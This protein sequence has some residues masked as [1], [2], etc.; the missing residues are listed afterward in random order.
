MLYLKVKEKNKSYVLLAIIQA[1]I[2]TGVNVWLLCYVKMGI[3]GY[4]VSMIVSR[5]V[6]AL[7]ACCFGTVVKDLRKARYDKV[8]LKEMVRYSVPLIANAVSWWVI[9]S[10]DKLMLESMLGE[11]DLGLYTAATKLPSFLNLFTS[12]FSQA[13]MISSIREY[14]SDDQKTFYSKV[15][16]YYSVFIIGIGM[17][18]NMFI[19]LIM[20]VYVGKEFIEAWT[21]VPMLM[22]S[23]MLAAFSSFLGSMYGAFRKSKNVMVTTLCGGIVNIVLNFCLIP[24]LGG[25]GAA[26]A[27]MIS[28]L[29]IVILRMIDVNRETKIN[30]SLKVFIPVFILALV[31]GIAITCDFMRI[32]ISLIA[33]ACVLFMIRKDIKM[34]M[35]IAKKMVSSRRK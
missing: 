21:T 16:K 22:L 31:Q 29:F 17:G 18:I 27:T 19:K 14:G 13:W 1:F 35:G 32:Q 15:F 7:L 23:A 28:Y 9:N 8:L 4:L 12:I 2:L 26:I 20:S 6:T 25:L 3:K 34:L 33:I 11:S 5:L 10:S 30:Y 24:R